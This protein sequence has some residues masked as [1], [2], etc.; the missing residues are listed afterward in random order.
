MSRYHVN[1]RYIVTKADEEG[2]LKVGDRVFFYPCGGIDIGYEFNTHT[3]YINSKDAERIIET[4]ELEIDR[5]WINENL[6]LHRTEI[7]RLEDAI[8][9]IRFPPYI[10]E[11]LRQREGLKKDDTSKDEFINAMSSLEAFGEVLIWNLG[12]RGWPDTII[13]WMKSC[14]VRTEDFS[15]NQEK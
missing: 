4:A 3:T 12:H 1:I 2:A 11:Y 7:K 10:M 13:G 8:R 14:G 6:A 15:D 9:E 5:E